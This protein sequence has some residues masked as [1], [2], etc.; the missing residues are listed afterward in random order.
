MRRRCRRQPRRTIL[1]SNPPQACGVDPIWAAS[2][3]ECAQLCLVRLA[4]AR[5]PALLVPSAEG[6]RLAPSP[7]MVIL[8]ATHYDAPAQPARIRTL[9]MFRRAIDQLRASPVG[10]RALDLTRP[11]IRRATRAILHQS[12]RIKRAPDPGPLVVSG[13]LSENSGIGKAGR[14]TVN[15][16]KLAG[17]TVI[18]HD[19][20]PWLSQTRLF[21]SELPA[22]PGGVWIV[23]CNPPEAEVILSRLRPD[24]WKSRYRIGYWAWELPTAPSTWLKAGAFFDEVWAPSAFTQDALSEAA[25]PV[26]RMS[27]PISPAEPED[28]P[29]CLLWSAPSDGLRCLAM[30]DLNSSAA[31]KNPMGAITLFKRAFPEPSGERE[32]IAKIRV[33]ARFEHTIEALQA[34]TEG[35]PDITLLS[36]ELS[37]EEVRSLIASATTVLSPHRAEGFGMVLAEAMTAGVT[38]LATGWSGNLD[39][40]AGLDPLL[41]PYA[42][43][44]IDDPSGIYPKQG[45]WPEPD[46]AA[47]AT[48]LR[49]LAADPALR[50]SPKSET[51]ARIAA[52][53]S[54]W[55][56]ERRT[57]EP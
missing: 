25:A 7:R 34:A 19:V 39:F 3:R 18:E 35:R 27:H 43:S 38:P 11:A 4:L 30:A 57:Q 8:A 26:R 15:A 6:R 49:A 31:R 52:C 36:R 1:G 24:A 48:K 51:A 21:A 32:L 9:S 14:C 20:R 37:D 23:H 17:Y 16:L 55:S 5:R 2:S 47:G 13:F 45:Q 56:R 22:P 40:M 28:T 44:D 10:A 42:L 46:L 41:I 50:A 33:H 29:P 54:G 53:W 12:A